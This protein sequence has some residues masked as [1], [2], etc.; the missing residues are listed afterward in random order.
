MR[1]ELGL[2]KNGKHILFAIERKK[3]SRSKRPV[4][5]QAGK[6]RESRTLSA[7]RQA[8]AE[9]QEPR[10]NRAVRG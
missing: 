10:R 4:C 1:R 7:D 6:K 5:R 9:N 3:E 8:R 2:G